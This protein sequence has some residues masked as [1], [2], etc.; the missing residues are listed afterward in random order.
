MDDDGRAA[1]RVS[2]RRN[3]FGGKV[4]AGPNLIDGELRIVQEELTQIRIGRQFRQ[5]EL[6]RH[7]RALDDWLSHHDPSVDG[8]PCCYLGPHQA[9][10]SLN[11]AGWRLSYILALVSI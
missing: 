1:C 7:S 11:M 8:D 10:A 3:W 5:D 6:N 9:N 2:G 4:E